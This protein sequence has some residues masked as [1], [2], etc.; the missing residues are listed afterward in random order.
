[1][2]PTIRKFIIVQTILKIV[3]IKYVKI[4]KSNYSE[5]PYSSK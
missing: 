3:G 5:F 4:E 2:S 1:M